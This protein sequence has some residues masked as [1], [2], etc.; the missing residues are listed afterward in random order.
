VHP[1][2]LLWGIT[3]LAAATRDRRII[4]AIVV[5]SALMAFYPMPAGGGPTA[6]ALF[7]ALGVLTGWLYL[8]LNPV[9]DEVWVAAAVRHAPGEPADEPRR[10]VLDRIPF[11][12]LPFD[13]LPIGPRPERS[14]DA[15]ET[16][17]RR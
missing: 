5:V 13:R 4:R 16:A 11:D 2:Y 9:T 1:W 7:G 12:R 10:S 14:A 8:R 17:G 15:G 6:G 3:V